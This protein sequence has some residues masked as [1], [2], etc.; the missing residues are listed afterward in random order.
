MRPL[1]AYGP[2][3]APD[4]PGAGHTRPAHR[5]F[6]SADHCARFVAELIATLGLN[7]V[8]LHGHSMGGLV[9]VLVADLAPK[10]LQRLI[11]AAAPLP[12]RP[13]PGGTGFGYRVALAAGQ[14]LARVLMQVGLRAKVGRVRQWLA[15]PETPQARRGFAGRIDPTAFSPEFRRLLSEELLRLRLRWRTDWAV[16]GFA[17]TFSALTVRQAAVRAV[18]DRLTV[19]VLY[20]WGERDPVI[21]RELVDE[22]VALRPDWQLEVLPAGHLVTWEAPDRYVTAVEA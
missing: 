2:V 8:V 19:P 21:P 12:G 15:E 6:A 17:S 11:L 3:V 7:Q 14:P 9:A 5:R 1:T 13:D 22:L 4:L 18:A 16:T 20:L 10:S